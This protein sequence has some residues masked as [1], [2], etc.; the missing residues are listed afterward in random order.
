MQAGH[1]GLKGAA[2]ETGFALQICQLSRHL[3]RAPHC[4]GIYPA[5]A[6]KAAA[7]VK[8]FNHA[9]VRGI[10]SCSA[11]QACCIHGRVEPREL[12]ATPRLPKN[13]SGDAGRFSLHLRL[14]LIVGYSQAADPLPYWIVRNSWGESWG[15][16][17]I[18]NL[19]G[20]AR[21]QMTFDTVRSEHML[22]LPPA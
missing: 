10:A 8:T 3:P 18:A 17:G 19:G 6:C 1:I 11:C 22:V 13:S 20:Y 21:V 7:G 12:R 5:S 14:Q 15:I 2:V 16:G 9:V 4:A